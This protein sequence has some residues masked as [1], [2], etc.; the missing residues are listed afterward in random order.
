MIG[1]TLGHYNILSSLGA[2]GMGEV[3][4]AEDTKLGRRVAL[5]VMSERLAGDVE[6]RRRFETEARAIAA[7]NHPGIVTV[8][9][10]EEV[11]GVHFLTMELVE[12]QTADNL[13]TA[14][15]L[16]FDRLCELAITLADAVGAAHERGVTHRDLKPANIMVTR[17]GGVKILDFGVAK[18]CADGIHE[19]RSEGGRSAFRS[20]EGSRASAG[21]SETLTAVLTRQGD[22]VGTIPYMSPEQLQGLPVDHR[23]DIFSLGVVLYELAAGS[24]PFPG[25]SIVVLASAILRDDPP[26]LRDINPEVSER[27]ARLVRRCLEKD[28]DRRWQS[29]VDLRNQLE[30]LAEGEPEPAAS[31]PSIGVLPF[32]DMSAEKDQ[33]WFCEGIAEEITNALARIDDLRVAS[34]MSAFQFKGAGGDSRAIG[35]KL[36]VNALLEGSV[37][38]AGDRLRINV[39]LVKVADGYRLWSERFDRKLE[40]VFTIQDEIAQQVVDAFQLTLAPSQQSCAE[41]PSAERLEAYE[42]Y[43]RGMQFVHRTGKTGCTIARE[44]YERAIDIDPTFAPACAWLATTHA[45]LYTYFDADPVHLERARELSSKALQLDAALPDAYVSRGMALSLSGSYDD[46]EQAFEIAI[47]LDSKSWAAPYYFA[48]L[49]WSRGELER[50]AELF[51]RAAEIQPDDFQAPALLSN[52]LEALHRP[53]EAVEAARRAS[54]NVE[55]RLET[56]PDDLRAL[57]LG[58]S[59]LTWLGEKRRGLEM[60]RRARISAPRDPAPLYNAACVYRYAGEI[61]SAAECW[62]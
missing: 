46:A 38:K 10:V 15:G 34:R 60:I 57:Y 44:M 56:T 51:Q 6:R 8:Y 31:P 58:A 4:V 36:G 32:A 7:L 2:G 11:D 9:S 61:E 37:R 14:G 20:D 29:A 62:K 12:G 49:C 48:R 17:G 22:V 33:D 13:I 47:G 21:D 42:Y 19:R 40:D 59:C 23:A 1:T 26:P 25:T 50:A 5:K 24:H 35:R 45:T 39:Q 55:R 54:A 41:K 43:L 53:A 28:P 52:V 18:L 27:F 3:F 16:A 30:E